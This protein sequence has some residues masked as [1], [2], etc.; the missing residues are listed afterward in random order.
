M[1]LLSILELIFISL[2]QWFTK[3][4]GFVDQSLTAHGRSMMDLIIPKLDF[5]FERFL[6]NFIWWDSVFWFL[7]MILYCEQKAAVVRLVFDIN[8]FE[9]ADHHCSRLIT[10]CSRTC[11]SHQKSVCHKMNLWQKWHWNCH[12]YLEVIHRINAVSG[13]NPR[14]WNFSRHYQFE[15][16]SSSTAGGCFFSVVPMQGV[17]IRCARVWLLDG[18]ILEQ[19]HLYIIFK[20]LYVTTNIIIIYKICYTVF[21]CNAASVG[22]CLSEKTQDKPR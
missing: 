6:L 14:L 22:G 3:K 4:D 17:V 21:K 9:P 20:I 10:N 18:S 11:S 13:H 8:V 16:V 2:F 19:A 12:I 1:A 5:I 15:R 7:L